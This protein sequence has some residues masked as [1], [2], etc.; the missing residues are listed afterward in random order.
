V[1]C[2]PLRDANSTKPGFRHPQDPSERSEEGTIDRPNHRAWLLS[3]EHSELMPQNEQFDV[4]GE[5]APPPPDQQPQQ[6]RKRKVSKG[7]QHPPMFPESRPRQ[8]G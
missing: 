5:R 1:R 2:F 8:P 6:R 3:T 7:K 4:L